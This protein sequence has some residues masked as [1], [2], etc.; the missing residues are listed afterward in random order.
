MS[1][2]HLSYDLTNVDS[3]D[4][5]EALKSLIRLIAEK[6]AGN[7]L[8]R[9]V[10]TSLVFCSSFDFELVRGAILSWSKERSAFYVVSEIASAP[11]GGVLCRMVSNK[12]LEV[13]LKKMMENDDVK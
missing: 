8:N 3:G 6:L 13:S 4:N 12:V 11:Q 10:R 1:Y 7:V 2:Y 9:P 5:D